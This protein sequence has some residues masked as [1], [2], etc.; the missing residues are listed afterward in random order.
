M[1]GTKKYPACPQPANTATIFMGRQ[2]FA[3]DIA[4]GDQEHMELEAEIRNFIKQM[5]QNNRTLPPVIKFYDYMCT[6]NDLQSV[7]RQQVRDC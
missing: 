1:L 6:I 7:L 4:E 2:I 5:L 3:T